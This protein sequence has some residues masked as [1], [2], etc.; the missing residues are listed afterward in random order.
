MLTMRL[1]EGSVTPMVDG[2]EHNLADS[3]GLLQKGIPKFV[4]LQTPLHAI[5]LLDDLRD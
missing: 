1:T 5:I 2:D 4:A 3:G